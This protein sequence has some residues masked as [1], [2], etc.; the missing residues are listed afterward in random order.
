MFAFVCSFSHGLQEKT[1]MI[2]FIEHILNDTIRL[3]ATFYLPYHL[4]YQKQQLIA[5]YPRIQGWLL[6][7]KQLDPNQV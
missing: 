5:A 3:G 6:L 4:H 7:K 2:S 1:K